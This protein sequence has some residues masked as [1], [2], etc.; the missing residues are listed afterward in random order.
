MDFIREGSLHPVH[1]HD[2]LESH[3]EEGEHVQRCLGIMLGTACGDILGAN[4][5]FRTRDE[6]VENHGEGPITTFLHSFSRPRGFF[7]DDTEMTLALAQALVNGKGHARC[8]ICAK[9]YVEFFAK[10]PRRGYGPGT[11]KVLQH[12]DDTNCSDA[13]TSGSVA[14]PTGSFGNGSC[15][16]I[17]PLGAVY[18]NASLDVL[19]AATVEACIST[20]SHQEAI[21]AAFVMALA[22]ARALRKDSSEPVSQEEALGLIEEMRAAT[23]CVELQG[24]LDAVI[25]A[26]A[27]DWDDMEAV[28]HLVTNMGFGDTFAIRAVDAM[29]CVMWGYLRYGSDPVLCLG[30]VVSWGGDADT[31][32]AI[33]GA[34]L[35]ARY[36]ATWIPEKWYSKIENSYHQ[37]RDL[38]VSLALEIA[39]FDSTDMPATPP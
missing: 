25:A 10:P 22:T 13:R 23:T 35:G 36:G 4:L 16:R 21:E 3:R 6:I 15:M 14:F 9:Q 29:A 28:R 17:A 19:R 32:G 30:T 31:V 11:T 20:H 38:L 26:H 24:R 27:E 18:R 7:T 8:D 12:L 39:S 2:L 33:L 34:L 1:I 5:E 37:G